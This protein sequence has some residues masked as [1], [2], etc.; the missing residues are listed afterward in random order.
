VLLFTDEL[1]FDLLVVVLPSVERLT[2]LP[3]EADEA[4]VLL[5]EAAEEDLSTVPL[6]VLRDPVELRFELRL[7]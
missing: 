1:P 6:D 2:V 3:D 4:S 7:E 5:E